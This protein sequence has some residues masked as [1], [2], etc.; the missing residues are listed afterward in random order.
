[1]NYTNK[2]TTVTEREVKKKSVIIYVISSGVCGFMF[3]VYI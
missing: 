3:N 1:M 2:Q